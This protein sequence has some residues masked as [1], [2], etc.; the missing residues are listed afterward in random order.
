MPLSKV[1]ISLGLSFGIVAMAGCQVISVKQQNT[2]KTLS[3]QRDSILNRST[4]SEAS[5][6]VLA[7]T[8]K[9]AVSCIGQAEHC[10]TALQHIPEL[11]D[12]QIL[13]TGS[14]IYLAQAIQLK[15]SSDCNA[16]QPHLYKQT[17]AEQR[18]AIQAFQQCTEQQLE[19]LTQSLR[20]SYAYLF[21][22]KRPLSQRLFDNRQVQVRD[23]YNQAVTNLIDTYNQRNEK[24]NHQL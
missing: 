13:S 16:N 3:N 22:S 4:L 21:A 8:G 10:I 15:K 9:E 11:L 6:N 14:E 18:H 17:E 24:K 2:A 7:M 12:E 19:A 1:F 23:F 5:L 20:Y